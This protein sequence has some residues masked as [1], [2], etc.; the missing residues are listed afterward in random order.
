MERRALDEKAKGNEQYKAGEYRPAIQSYTTALRLQ[1]NNA[2]VHANRGMCHLKLKQYRQALADCTAAVQIDATYTKAYLRR[3]IAHRRL[4]QHS[5]AI[6]DLDVVLE[7]EPRN[8]EAT[9]HRRCSQIELEKA[10]KER[11]AAAGDRPIAAGVPK[12]TKLII[13]EVD[14]DSDDEGGAADAAPAANEAAE[15]SRLYREE[16][17]KDRRE[18][19][20]AARNEAGLTDAPGAR[21]GRNVDPQAVQE[22][23]SLL[24][25]LA[26]MGGPGTFAADAA[27]PKPKQ[28]PSQHADKAKA[29]DKGDANFTPAA[30]F[31]GPRPGMVFKSGPR[32]VGYYRDPH[33]TTAQSK[34][35]PAA[36]GL[37]RM[38]IEEDDEDDDEEEP[39]AGASASAAKA[40][41]S[42]MRRLQIE[43]DDDDDDDE[44]EAAQ[45]TGS[46]QVPKPAAAAAGGMRRMQIVESDDDDDEAAEVPAASAPKAGEMRRMQIAESDDEEEE[47]AEVPAA[48]APKASGMRRMQIEES[49][50]EEEEVAEVP[51]A[52]AP[53][54]GG[55]R[56]MQIAEGDDDEEEESMTPAMRA[57]I[58]AADALRAVGNT[59]FKKSQ[60]EDA[61]ATYTQAID[62]VRASGASDDA[63]LVK[64]FNNR[65]A[66]N[67]ALQQYK[68]AID[69][70]TE[71]LHRAPGDAKALMR[72]A[73]SSEALERYRDALQDMR[74]VVALQP[75]AKDA[76]AACIR[77]SKLVAT[78]DKEK[79]ASASDDSGK[80]AAANAATAAAKA[81]AAADEI[82][83]KGTAAFRAGDYK[84]AAELYYEAS[85]A[86][87][88][89]H[90]HFSNLALALLKLG[91][92]QH[93]VT[94]AQRCTE[95]APQFSKGHYRLGMALDA[96][97]DFDA[98]CAAFR[99]GL[100]HASGS[101]AAE[102]Q[103]E[104][105][106]CEKKRAAAA[107]A[108]ATAAA[109]A[110]SPSRAE[111][112]GA[113]ESGSAGS[114]TSPTKP[115]SGGRVDLGKAAEMAKRVAER[116]QASSQSPI[117]GSPQSFTAFERTFSQ[118]W[119][120]GKCAD[121]TRLR[122][123]LELLPA[124]QAD[125]VAFVGD[126]L[127]AEL[128]SALVLAAE[129]VLSADE[130]AAAVGLLCRLSA[131]RRFDMLWMFVEKAEHAAAEQI[132]R[133]AVADGCVQP[134]DEEIVAV[135][136]RCGIKK[137]LA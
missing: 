28:T 88:E 85:R 10:E 124:A 120:R 70:C 104:L 54:A 60:Y 102:L 71:V 49:D 68:Q 109:A 4:G 31:A 23:Q 6:T 135:C 79:G 108:A 39:A 14:G 9:E 76:S 56:R 33:S 52:S 26:K 119:A 89:C 22:S 126:S 132:V 38:Q 103:R 77:L 75:G 101:E 73:F 130:P 74:A 93:A 53:K 57:A 118:V 115:R 20:R 48:S 122:A 25:S 46:A 69:D 106:A 92:P 95:L 129:R 96:R 91:Q 100:P 5:Q 42:G 50:D 82:K 40:P 35:P 134:G 43:D 78:L 98:A 67:A 34:A 59:H 32:G 127:S 64:C 44:E 125:L 51:A 36:G 1:Q 8:A 19:E 62:G 107:A 37:R 65:A 72:R 13:E 41:A 128:L 3:G 2:V 15:L 29:E 45:A 21:A 90:T 24:D 116:A 87:P 81:A 16:A 18:R 83:V 12:Q 30:R 86:A 110:A 58:E 114:P 17:E 99:T 66:S 113:E 84:K 131:V 27:P 94:A 133:R 63:L 61:I 117:A 136:K 7:H 121:A 55:M 105:D 112:S 47:V 11:K 137:A 111:P 97:G 123:H 80:S